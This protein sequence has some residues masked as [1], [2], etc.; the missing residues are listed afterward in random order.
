[1]NNS[2]KEIIFNEVK[3]QGFI[4]I[5]RD[6]NKVDCLTR[7][8]AVIAGGV[9]VLEISVTTPNAF[10]AIKELKEKADGKYFVGAGTVITAEICQNALNAGA[11]FII[12]PN[13]DMKVS[14]ICNENNIAYIPGVG[15]MTEIC[16]A[17]SCGHKMLKLFPAHSI[18]MDFVKMAKAPIPEA[19]LI[20][21]GGINLCEAKEWYK[22]GSFALAI[23]SALTNPEKDKCDY[24]QIKKNAE[25]IV[26][27]INKLKLLRNI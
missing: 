7:A 27:I 3:E 2:L 21:T 20:P 10:D 6:N 24:E 26:N 18:G 19:C 15:T 23:G 13:F 1:M 8:E 5:V 25:I 4:C 9:K 16:N 22:A 14:E 11:D 12:A 17:L